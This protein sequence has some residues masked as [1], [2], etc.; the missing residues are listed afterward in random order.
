M[1]S[2]SRHPDCATSK[3]SLNIS[4]KDFT[5]TVDNL[6]EL[7]DLT[8]SGKIY[9]KDGCTEETCAYCPTLVQSGSDWLNDRGIV[10]DIDSYA[11]STACRYYREKLFLTLRASGTLKLT[12]VVVRDFRQQYKSVIESLGGTL[13]F[14]DTDFINMQASPR[15]SDNAIISQRACE[16][17]F[18]CGSF[19]YT[20][21]TIT[22]LNNG[23]EWK[24]NSSSTRALTTGF[25]Y[26]NSLT[27][28]KLTG[29]T[30]TYNYIYS[31]TATNPVGTVFRL[32]DA[33][34]LLI[35]SCEFSYN[36]A[37]TSA[38]F[39]LTLS[40]EWPIISSDGISLYHSLT[41]VEL[42]NTLITR[43]TALNQG[44]FYINAVVETPNVIIENCTFLTNLSLTSGPINI[45]SNTNAL[46]RAQDTIVGGV[47]V[48]ASRVEIK[49]T[50]IEDNV[51]M[52][53]GLLSIT[54]VPNL[55]LTDVDIVG[56]GSPYG[57]TF[58][59]KSY[60]IEAFKNNPDIYF[61]LDIPN[62][63]STPCANLG[64]IG[65]S[66]NVSV[67]RVSYSYNSCLTASSSLFIRTTTTLHLTD[68]TIL[69]N[70][71]DLGSNGRA[72]VIGASTTVA[73]RLKVIGNIN[74]KFTRGTIEFGA[75]NSNT[76]ATVY[77]KDSLIDSNY[78]EATGVVYL[79]SVKSA[80]FDSCTFTK[81]TSN[82]QG[83]VIYAKPN[84]NY[85]LD[86]TLLSCKFTGNKTKDTG[87]LFV[88]KADVVVTYVID[89]CEF[90]GNQ[91]SE[92]VA[93]YLEAT[94]SSNSKMVN[95]VVQRNVSGNSATV[96]LKTSGGNFAIKNCKFIQNV[97]PLTAVID[98]TYTSGW[99][100]V[101]DS[102]FEGNSG[103]NVF[104]IQQSI[105][106]QQKLVLLR[107]RFTANTGIS[108][109]T[110]TCDVT[111]LDSTY[112]DNYNSAVELS[113]SSTGT[114]TNIKFNRNVGAEIG[115]A[116][117]ISVN[118]N[119]ICKACEFLDNSSTDKAGAVYVERGSTFWAENST[120]KGNKSNLASVMYLMNTKLLVSKL[121]GCTVTDNSS[122]SYGSI[123]LSESTLTFEASKMYGNIEV[124]GLSPGF[125][126][127]K[128]TLNVIKSELSD[129]SSYKGSLIYSSFFSTVTIRDTSLLRGNATSTGGALF[130][131]FSFIYIFNSEFK[132]SNASNGGA[133]YLDYCFTTITNSTFTLNQGTTSGGDIEAN[134]GWLTVYDTTFSGS[135]R[136]SLKL[137]SLFAA[138]L[139]GVT[140]RDGKTSTQ[141]T[142]S[143]VVALTVLNSIFTMNNGTLGSVMYASGTSS[144]NFTNNL[145]SYNTA[146]SG[147]ALYLNSVNATF[148][149]N[150]FLSNHAICNPSYGG[151]VE[152]VCG[153]GC[154]SNFTEN[155]FTLNSALIN[156]G[157]LHW[158]SLAPLIVN[159]T[160]TNNSAVYGN[161]YA[162]YIDA[163]VMVN[164]VG[165]K[166]VNLTDI[167]VSGQMV[168]S[169]L[170]FNLID[171]QGQVVVSDNSTICELSSANAQFSGAFRTSS[172]KGVL[173]F[174]S[175]KV[176]APPG[177][178]VAI[179]AS[180]YGDSI[181]SH[182]VEFYL[183]ECKVGE[184]QKGNECIIC[185][186]DTY[187]F[188]PSDSCKECF[189]EAQCYGNYT[190]VPKEG[191]WR[192]DYL[193]KSFYT[194]PRKQSCLGP[195]D[196]DYS[197]TGKCE[198]GYHGTLCS[199]C[200][201]GYSM[202]GR[203]EC[204]ECI[205]S[206][207]TFTMRV[208]LGLLIVAFAVGSVLLSLRT[209]TRTRSLMSVYFKI[210]MNYFQITSVT[211]YFK[212]NWPSLFVQLISANLSVSDTADKTFSASCI[213][214][215]LNSK[216][217]FY[218]NVIVLSVVPF[219]LI[220]LILGVWGG[221]HIFRAVTYWR[222]KLL[223]SMTVLIFL[224]HPFLTKTMFSIFACGQVENDFWLTSDYSIKCWDS[225]HYSYVMKYA[226]PSLV[227]WVLF[228]PMFCVVYLYKKRSKLD[229]VSTKFVLGFLYHGYKPEVFY[230]EFVVL[231]RKISIIVVAVFMN[232][233]ETNQAVTAVLLLFFFY[234]L[235]IR[236]KPYITF[237]LNL[238]EELSIAVST[239]TISCG[240]YFL[241]NETGTVAGILLFTIVTL[242]NASFFLFWL[243]EASSL[244]VSVLSQR[245]PKLAQS[246]LCSRVVYCC[247]WGCLDFVNVRSYSAVTPQSPLEASA[248]RKPPANSFDASTF[249]MK[250]NLD[251][252]EAL[253]EPGL[254]KI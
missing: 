223:G 234:V 199:G 112:T 209:A 19:E 162:S 214:S 132:G 134:I 72:F 118:S 218:L 197:L 217:N 137:N 81:N 104:S 190:V 207:K 195:E 79:N 222:E 116:I 149:N 229:E 41:H 102:S 23:Y 101:S 211:T 146:C 109:A 38:S 97:S 27:L 105:S 154:A 87:S 236:V 210:L 63:S 62:L 64:A 237:K 13:I 33:L 178:T 196:S 67:T 131:D 248:G 182:T 30:V 184:E 45:G 225:E 164:V 37:S 123:Y 98:A 186:F 227:V 194:C 12:S 25:L 156:G 60:T 187:S 158:T 100:E 66:E 29:V 235:Q 151:A 246:M 148:T 54:N 206:P 167:I 172:T 202:T 84:L 3:A 133:L 220:V 232:A 68:F 44:I 254:S 153:V 14:T 20:R 166:V 47:K 22:Q 93:L 58:K 138:T 108:L 40:R 208:L 50:R 125:N 39:A 6:L 111:D 8:L 249:M 90:T 221:V 95:S 144:L 52:P 129:Q 77:V 57:R 17:T 251:I 128:S 1:C 145:F 238:T 135:Q 36:I 245:F 247:T 179:V 157:A 71:Q 142:A 76:E 31:A 16:S 173:A 96:F 59:I 69:S 147:G 228:L 233:M 244:T 126:L 61:S 141:I 192:Q 115:G 4:N 80:I 24:D 65:G 160:F 51:G 119:L 185:G 171:P 121:L 215:D 212:L 155:N 103:S 73:L 89:S 191:Y 174:K 114:F 91:A 56:N 204:S 9:L 239:A 252:T 2:T 113:N 213:F 117:F 136:G 127:F 88:E 26:A 94:I 176:S 130:G 177:S 53:I 165:S 230:W 143:N 75:K 85:N 15:D 124:G 250:D 200:I 107:N 11:E 139:S 175:F 10:I 180:C 49:S 46:Y 240:L 198:K 21:G 169:G 55:S 18:Y 203:H 120:F 226:M 42:K 99:L 152:I 159:N 189:S 150:T 188:N 5:L 70:Y 168:T 140:V 205:Q 241:T 243:K 122:V 48:P 224:I 78:A 35:D 110:Q 74:S 193:S 163:I 83:G 34:Q 43:N 201:E 219:A 170:V 28:V 82:D 161:D 7:R 32:N 253:K 106:T 181:A 183:R 231:Y 86:V 216:E 92:G 242:T